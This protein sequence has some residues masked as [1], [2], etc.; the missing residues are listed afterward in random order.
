MINKIRYPL[1]ES[2]SSNTLWE[3]S[4]VFAV[5][6]WSGFVFSR[7]LYA[8]LFNTIRVSSVRE[9]GHS[10]RTKVTHNSLKTP[11]DVFVLVVGAI[12]FSLI[13]FSVV[14]LGWINTRA[15]VRAQPNDIRRGILYFAGTLRTN[16]MS[17]HEVEKYRRIYF[18][19]MCKLTASNNYYKP[20]STNQ[21]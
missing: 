6:I 11:S 2:P 17:T 15:R 3:I 13:F 7:R 10:V 12:W 14:Y 19:K 20:S 8:D 9:Y 18:D 1:Y 21:W 4:L 5:Y 16:V